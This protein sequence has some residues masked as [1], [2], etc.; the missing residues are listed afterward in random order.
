MTHDQL[1]ELAPWGQTLRHRTTM[2]VDLIRTRCKWLEWPNTH[3][4]NPRA[5]GSQGERRHGTE[6]ESTSAQAHGI[7]C[8]H[9]MRP[10]RVP[11]GCVRAWSS[12][13]VLF[14]NHDQ[15]RWRVR[16]RVLPGCLLTITAGGVWEN[17]CAPLPQAVCAVEEGG[18]WG[19]EAWV[20]LDVLGHHPPDHQRADQVPRG[21]KTLQAGHAERRAAA[22]ARSRVGPPAADPRRTGAQHGRQRGGPRHPQRGGRGRVLGAHPA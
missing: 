17:E 9:A 5:P 18:G 14:L 4:A 22:A 15:R 2:R 10:S 3:H 20:S 6:T 21:A 13:W 19:H 8:Q 11:G 7:K 16:V 1:L 12:V